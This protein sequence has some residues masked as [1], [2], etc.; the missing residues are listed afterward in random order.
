MGGDGSTEEVLF[1]PKLELL[2]SPNANCLLHWP[3]H[4]GVSKLYLGGS[5][6][7]WEPEEIIPFLPFTLWPS[8]S[9]SFFSFDFFK[10]EILIKIVNFMEILQLLCRILLFSVKPQHESA[11]DIYKS[12][13]FWTSLPSLSSFH[14]SRLIQSPYLS[15][16]AIE[17]IPVGYLFSIW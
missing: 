6:H 5:C 14:P 3:P 17:Q 15:F 10:I 4:C 1:Q 12:P 13:P 16:V 9:A 11:I 8:I 7:L 2:E